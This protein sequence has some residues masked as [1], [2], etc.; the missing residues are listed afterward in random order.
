MISYPQLLYYS[1]ESIPQLVK[2]ATSSSCVQLLVLSLSCF[3]RWAV[4]SNGFQ[5][6]LIKISDTVKRT[7]RSVRTIF[8]LFEIIYNFLFIHKSTAEGFID[9]YQIIADY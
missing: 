8:F 9:R 3:S 2:D 6:G 1:W 5:S 4:E 7:S